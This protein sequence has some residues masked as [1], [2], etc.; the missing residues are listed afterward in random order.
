MRS[1]GYL[2]LVKAANRFRGGRCKFSTYADHMVRWGILTHIRNQNR[3]KRKIGTKIDP[4]WHLQQSR[5]VA[6]KPKRECL[7]VVSILKGL[8]MN[9]AP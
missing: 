3:A 2:A 7:D 8:L 5:R 1:I 9:G 4:D 6:D